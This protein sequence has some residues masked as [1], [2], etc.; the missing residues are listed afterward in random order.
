[1]IM[2]A[3]VCVCVMRMCTGD[4]G[5]DGMC[6]CRKGPAAESGAGRGP[7]PHRRGG[8]HPETQGQ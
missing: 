1:M 2:A 3:M 6:R 8:E 7:Q 4:D 5:G